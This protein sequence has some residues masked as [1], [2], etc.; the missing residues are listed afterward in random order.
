MPHRH[1]CT[2]ELDLEAVVEDHIGRSDLD[3][4]RRRQFFPHI[5]GVFGRRLAGGDAAV[6][7][8]IAPVHRRERDKSFGG[9]CVSDDWGVDLDP[10]KDVIPMRVRVYDRERVCCVL[11]SER[12]EKFVRVRS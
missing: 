11:R 4:P 12:S 5:R 8:F 2:S 9:Q 6:E 10:A 1:G 7:T 3:G